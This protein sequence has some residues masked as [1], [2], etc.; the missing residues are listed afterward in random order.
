MWVLETP[1]A[2]P[3]WLLPLLWLP[4]SPLGS[5]MQKALT[6]TTMHPECKGCSF[7]DAATASA[8]TLGNSLGAPLHAAGFETYTGAAGDA[9]CLDGN[10]N[11]NGLEGR[12]D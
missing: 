8:C 9:H 2:L 7:D 11:G 4:A 6:G 3:G 10:G 1:K 12:G 5:K